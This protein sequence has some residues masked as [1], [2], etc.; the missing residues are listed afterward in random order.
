MKN[1]VATATRHRIVRTTLPAWVAGAPPAEGAVYGPVSH[2]VSWRMGSLRWG[3]AG[4]WSLLPV[5]PSPLDMNDDLIA[6]PGYESDTCPRENPTCAHF[7]KKQPVQKTIDIGAQSDGEGDLFR[8]RHSEDLR[9]LLNT[10]TADVLVDEKREPGEKQTIVPMGD[11]WWVRKPRAGFSSRMRAGFDSDSDD[12]PPTKPPEDH[13]PSVAKKPRYDD[14]SPNRASSGQSAKYILGSWKAPPGQAPSPS[15]PSSSPACTSISATP[16]PAP[17]HP[18]A[19]HLHHA[20]LPPPPPNAQS[21]TGTLAFFL[22]NVMT[23]LMEAQGFSVPRLGVVATWGRGAIQETLSRLLM[24][25]E[26]AAGG[27][28]G[29]SA[30]EAITLELAIRKL[31]VIQPA[32]AQNVMGLD[33]RAH[34]DLLQTQGFDVARLSGIATWDRTDIQEIFNRSLRGDGPRVSGRGMK[35]L[36]VLALEFAV[37]NVG[38]AG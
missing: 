37:H 12:E 36:E 13:V 30:M 32:A 17:S 31:K 25:S 2:R 10:S 28:K 29:M 21:S 9:Y 14:A 22:K 7:L 6:D 23:D 1:V 19:V 8:G 16:S 18:P 24:G 33:L 15:K 27:R 38:K 26:P 5:L 3:G 11:G 34:H 20:L 4:Q 35:A